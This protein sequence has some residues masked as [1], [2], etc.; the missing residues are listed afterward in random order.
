MTILS[1]RAAF[2]LLL[3][4]LGPAVACSQ[5]K[6]S[7]QMSSAIDAIAEQSLR[8][9]PIPGMSIAVARGSDVLLAKDMDLQ[10]W[11]TTSLHPPILSITSI[12]SAR[13]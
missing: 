2:V 1:A 5:Q 3:A 13:I 6:L 4:S 9:G 11:K 10:T 12:R 7:A 8:R